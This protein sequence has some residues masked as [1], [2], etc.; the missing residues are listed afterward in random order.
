MSRHAGRLDL[1]DHDVFET[2]VRHKATSFRALHLFLRGCERRLVNPVNRLSDTPSRRPVEVWPDIGAA[3]IAHY[4][5]HAR[6]QL[7][8]GDLIM[9]FAR[10]E[11]CIVVAARIG[12]VDEQLRLFAGALILPPPS[13]SRFSDQ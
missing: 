2:C 11:G 8:V 12:A 5:Y 1:R 10:I 13:P 6:L 4:A 3:M 7:I 9:K